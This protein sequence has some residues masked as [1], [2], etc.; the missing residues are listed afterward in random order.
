MIRSEGL[1]RKGMHY[2]ILEKTSDQCDWPGRACAGAGGAGFEIS[3]G[4]KDDEETWKEP[5]R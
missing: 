1:V 2:E 5:D 4:G 3:T